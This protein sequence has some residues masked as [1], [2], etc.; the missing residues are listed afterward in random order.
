MCSTLELSG[1]F[2]CLG[3]LVKFFSAWGTEKI[4]GLWF[5]KRDQYP[6]WH[7]D[8]L[9]AWTV[10]IEI[11][12]ILKFTKWAKT[13]GITFKKHGFLWRESAICW[14]F[15]CCSG[16]NKF[17]YASVYKEMKL[18]MDCLT[19]RL[20]L[21]KAASYKYQFYTEVCVSSRLISQ[22]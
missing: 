22:I 16:W 8:S 19:S 2:V 4:A 6:G 1:L 21:Q 9:E 10:L 18:E 14:W 5:A 12:V 3:V 20:L 13:L 15:A 11:S 17:W 7:Y